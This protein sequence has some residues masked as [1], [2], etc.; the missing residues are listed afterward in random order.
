MSL[1]SR[2]ERI[3]SECR[4]TPGT[5]TDLGY[6]QIEVKPVERENP[7]S[8]DCGLQKIKERMPAAQMGFLGN[9]QWKS[10]N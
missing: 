9:E 5:F 1:Q 10:D 2:L 7:A 3:E 8:F 6:G 4:L